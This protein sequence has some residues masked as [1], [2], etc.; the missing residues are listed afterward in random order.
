MPFLKMPL[1]NF[2]KKYQ[3][4]IA[5]ESP[6]MSSI[7]IIG[8]NTNNEWFPKFPIIFFNMLFGILYQQKIE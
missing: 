8:G 2:S 5:V 3:K 4:A 1:I 6:K 7:T